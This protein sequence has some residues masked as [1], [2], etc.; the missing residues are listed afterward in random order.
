MELGQYFVP[1]GRLPKTV[2]MPTVAMITLYT[3]R[4]ADLEAKVAVTSR[5]RTTLL[6]HAT[7]F[8]ALPFM[9]EGGL[10]VAE[11]IINQVGLSIGAV[12]AEPDNLFHQMTML[13]GE[14]FFVAVVAYLLMSSLSTVPR[15]TLLVPLAQVRH[16]HC[17]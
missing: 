5:L 3:L 13:S 6:A 14:L 1:A 9:F 16:R 11:N 15:W 2:L 10:D 4:K 8:S 7:Y 17:V 12:P